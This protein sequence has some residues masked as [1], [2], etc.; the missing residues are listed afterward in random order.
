MPGTLL[1]STPFNIGPSSA[2]IKPR[3]TVSEL[4]LTFYATALV[5]MGNDKRE[6]S[7]PILDREM[8]EAGKLK[9][10]EKYLSV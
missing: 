7:P 9:R 5:I 1:P 3:V 10:Q 2:H 4:P 6:Y 8:H